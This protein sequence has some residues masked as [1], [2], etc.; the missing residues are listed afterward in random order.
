MS[1]LIEIRYGE[2][3]SD[4]TY[5]YYVTIPAGMTVRQFINEW[6]KSHEHDWGCFRIKDGESYLLVKF[7]CDYSHGEIIGEPF[8]DDVLDKTIVSVWGNG[9]WSCSDF[10][11]TVKGE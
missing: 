6:L 10:V 4:D 2:P 3:L 7:K 11:F 9:G 1:E 5:P 8:P